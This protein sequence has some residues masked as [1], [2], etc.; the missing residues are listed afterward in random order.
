MFFR[1]ETEVL[2]KNIGSELRC[3]ERYVT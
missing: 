3:T 1:S 2:H